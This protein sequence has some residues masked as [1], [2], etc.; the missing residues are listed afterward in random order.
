MSSIDEKKEESMA[1]GTSSGQEDETTTTKVASKRQ[2]LE[3]NKA[4]TIKK[5]L[6]KPCEIKP[7]KASEALARVREFLPLM[8]ESTNKLMEESKLNPSAV[9]IENVDDEDEHIQMDLALMPEDSDSDSDEDDDDDDEDEEDED[10]S[11]EDDEDDETKESLKEL[12]LEFKVTDPN[13][14]KRLKLEKP[15]AATSTKKLISE[16]SNEGESDSVETQSKKQD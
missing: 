2:Y 15:N 9:D 12:G 13:R 3:V 16:I 4:E 11:E 14:I 10:E 7:V 6:I 1:A 5:L 8:K